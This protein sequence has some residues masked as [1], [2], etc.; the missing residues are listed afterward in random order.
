M[1]EFPELGTTEVWRFVNRSG[2]T[3]P[4]H[5]HLV[6]FQVLDRQAFEEVGG[7]VVPIG[8]PV[9]PP[10]HEAGWKDTVQVGPNEMVRVIARF[11]DYAGLFAYHCHILEHEDHEMMREFR[12]VQCGNGAGEPGEACDDGNTTSGDGCFSTCDLESSLELYGLAQ[13][14]SVSVTVS[15]VLVSV[16]TTAGQTPAQVVA[17]LASA[18]EA[19]ATLAAEGVGAVALGIRL[20]TNGTIDATNVADPGLFTSPVRV[21][22]LSPLGFALAA[23]LML[24]G[25]GH[26]LARRPA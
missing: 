2:V 21:P 5:M 10:P 17:A 19:D 23:L 8:S 20:V 16:V 9:P 24:V 13:G 25:A 1:T 18:I 3:H 26:L 11:E 22:S 12:T 7:A 6:A 15:A 4:M 14:G